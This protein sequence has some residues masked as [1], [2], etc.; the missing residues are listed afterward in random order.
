MLEQALYHQCIGGT[1]LVPLL[2]MEM[3]TGSPNNHI[4]LIFFVLQHQCIGGIG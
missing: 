1:V 3:Q 2:V 4:S